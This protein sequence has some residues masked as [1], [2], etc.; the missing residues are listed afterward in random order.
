[1][2]KEVYFGDHQ[3]KLQWSQEMLDDLK[4]YSPL[5]PESELK[6]LEDFI[7]KEENKLRKK[8]LDSL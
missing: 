4:K 2:I 6:E 7:L 8:K 1:M 3:F 5:D